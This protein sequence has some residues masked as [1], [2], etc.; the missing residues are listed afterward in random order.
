AAASQS[1]GEQ[2]RELQNLMAFFKLDERVVS[3][4][5]AVVATSGSSRPTSRGRPAVAKP[6]A[7]TTVKPAA[8][9]VAKPV[10]KS[11]PAEKK[12]AATHAASEEWE[13]F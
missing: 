9:P 8:K 11:A 6:M 2:A 7:K 3:E 4:K 5:P 10:A 12:S 1:M 13:E